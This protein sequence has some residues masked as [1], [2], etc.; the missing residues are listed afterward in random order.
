MLKSSTGNVVLVL[1]FYHGCCFKF[2]WA[3]SVFSNLNKEKK[4]KNNGF[5]RSY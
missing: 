3:A 2:N 1:I 5:V 4:K